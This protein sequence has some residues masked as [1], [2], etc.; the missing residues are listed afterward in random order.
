MNAICS[1]NPI[2][3]LLTAGKGFGSAGA[4]PRREDAFVTTVAMEC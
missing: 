3:R 1:G 2:L 4:F